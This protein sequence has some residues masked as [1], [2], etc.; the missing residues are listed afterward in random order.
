VIYERRLSYTVLSP[1]IR[2]RQLYAHT[3]S[4]CLVVEPWRLFTA[5]F[6]CDRRLP[7]QV[8]IIDGNWCFSFYKFTW[9]PG[10]VRPRQWQFDLQAFNITSE[11]LHLSV[12]LFFQP[13]GNTGLFFN[14]EIPVLRDF[15]SLDCK[16]AFH[17]F[18]RLTWLVFERLQIGL[19]L[20]VYRN[21]SRVLSYSFHVSL[22]YIHYRV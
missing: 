17:T 12:S 15:Q 14:P 22:Q 8:L 18:T 4:C 11:R 13:F 20:R 19:Y 16:F 2:M 3:V 1:V 21:V 6:L 10:L 9:S 7:F 5:F